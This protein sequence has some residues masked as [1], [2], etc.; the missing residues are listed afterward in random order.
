MDM[1]AIQVMA[2]ALV[3]GA[4]GVGTIRAAAMVETP[5]SFS[6]DGRAADLSHWQRSKIA[7]ADAPELARPGGELDRTRAG[8]D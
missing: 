2:L 7:T 4:A 8:M 3:C 5:V 1:K 6:Y